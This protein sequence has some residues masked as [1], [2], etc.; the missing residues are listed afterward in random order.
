MRAA[1]A[2]QFGLLLLAAAGCAEL[3]RPPPAPPPAELVGAAPDTTRAA[4]EATAIAFADRGAGLANRPAA[5]AQAIAQLEFVAADL[6]RNP[7]WAPLPEGIQRQVL[8]AR[9]ELRDALGIAENADPDSVVAA[10]LAAARG[11]RANDRAA[12]AAALPAPL[13]RPGGAR[14]VARLGELGPLPQAANA[15]ALAVQEVARIDAE[16]RWLGNRPVDA[17]GHQVTTF[18][19]SGGSDGGGGGGY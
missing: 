1:L 11:L 13:F 18:G 7:R 16:G 3:T 14:S 5:A 8:L 4:I 9:M 10:L 2:G 15:T 6:P 17:A 19:F 12:A